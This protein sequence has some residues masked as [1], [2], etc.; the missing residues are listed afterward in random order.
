MDQNGRP[1]EIEDKVN[2]I[3]LANKQKWRNIPQNR[4]QENMLKDLDSNHLQENIKAI[5][6]YRTKWHKNCFQKNSS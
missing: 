3:L 4:E 6:G 2:L 1:L 5:I